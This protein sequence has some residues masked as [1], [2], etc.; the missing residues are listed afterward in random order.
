MQNDKQKKKASDELASS[1]V[2]MLM[3]LAYLMTI[4]WVVPVVPMVI[5]WTLDLSFI[6]F[7]VLWS[8][9]LPLLSLLWYYLTK[10][11]ASGEASIKPNQLIT[12]SR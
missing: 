3:N 7:I 8:L 11:K 2:S 5:T 12:A 1:T 10:K 6:A 9:G 4:C